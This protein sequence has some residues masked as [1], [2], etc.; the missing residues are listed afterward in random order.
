MLALLHGLMWDEFIPPLNSVNDENGPS[1]R[2]VVRVKY[3]SQTMD[4]VLCY[5]RII[6]NG[7]TG[8]CQ[9]CEV[10]LV[11]I[12]NTSGATEKQQG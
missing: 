11:Y 9:L 6:T 1:L 5:I 12:Y 4:S 2:N 7:L 3:V 8:R 10:C